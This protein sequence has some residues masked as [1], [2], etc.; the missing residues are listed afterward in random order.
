[1]VSDIEKWVR[2]GGI[3]ITLAQTGRHTPE[4]PD[5]WPISRLTGYRVEKID[6]LKPDGS[7][8]ETGVLRSA[9][10]EIGVQRRFERGDRQRPSPEK[11]A[12]DVQD[13]LLWNDGTV[14]AGVRPVGKGF[15][16]ELGAK[17]SGASISDRMEPGAADDP[18]NLHMRQMLTALLQWRKVTPEP[19]R[20][21]PYND[22]VILRHAVSNNGLYDVWTLW[23]QSPTVAQTASVTIDGGQKPPFFIDMANGAQ[24]PL[25][26]ASLDNIA[27]DPLDTRVFLTPRQQ[28][29]QAP[30]EW[31][32]LQRKWWRGAA[33]PPATPLPGPDHRF[34]KDLTQGW[35]FQPLDASASALP[36]AAA[37]FD[38]SS[39]PSRALGVWDVKGAGGTGRAVFRKTFTVPAD[40]TKGRVSL[41]MTSWDQGA[42]RDSFVDRGEVWLDG[43]E[44]KSLTGGS[45]IAT[46]LPALTAGSSHQLTVEAEGAGVLAGFRGECWLAFEPEASD[47]IDLAGEWSTS[48][49]G[50]TYGAP[51]SLPGR[52]S[53]QFLRRRFYID[54]RY[55]GRNAVLT[56]DGA[57]TLVSVLINGRLVRHNAHMLSAR[58]SL[59]LTPFVRF[60]ADNEI[61]LV[62]WDKPGPGFVKE[63]SMGFF[64]P[65]F[66]P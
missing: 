55:K 6:Q 9:P 60:G 54:A 5:S 42:P 4:R 50:L 15:I 59:N 30:A 40:W 48:A 56:V 20:L 53:T 23:N 24:T 17:F 62:Q 34:S 27:L 28:I 38:D 8:G 33:K 18:A 45:L 58:W 1:M 12:D 64:D 26:A 25:A 13:L 21:N 22:L 11:D 51:V 47:K 52:Y 35:K 49:D 10:G 66:Y 37:D 2:D 43:Q 3:F 65:K 36:M 29:T 31:F 16:V 61:Q 39:W 32:D 41:W 57:P 46:D 19:G 14:A 63:A 7:V 44:I